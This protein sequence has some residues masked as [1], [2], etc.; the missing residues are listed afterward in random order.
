M[1][2]SNKLKPGHYISVSLNESQFEGVGG[3]PQRDYKSVSDDYENQVKDFFELFTDACKLRLRSDV[4]IGIALSGGLDSSA[5][6]ST[7]KSGLRMKITQFAFKLA[8]CFYCI[9]S[10]YING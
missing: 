9:F 10:R 2:K 6:Y 5:V 7:V 1:N 8:N 4:P 3:T